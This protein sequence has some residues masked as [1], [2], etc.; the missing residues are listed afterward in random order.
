[1]NFLFNL[2]FYT[3]NQSFFLGGGIILEHYLVIHWFSK[4]FVPYIL[5]PTPSSSFKNLQK[6]NF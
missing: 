4:E 6:K 3:H 5:S 2:K 1:M